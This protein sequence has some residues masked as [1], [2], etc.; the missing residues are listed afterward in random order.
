[1]KRFQP[2]HWLNEHTRSSQ[3]DSLPFGADPRKCPEITF[4]ITEMKSF[5]ATFVRTVGRYELALHVDE[6]ITWKHVNAIVMPKDRVQIFATD[7]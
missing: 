3:Q 4:A 6:Q 1:M 7:F 2:S 5:I